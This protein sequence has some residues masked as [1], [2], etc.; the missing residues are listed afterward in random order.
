MPG[1]FRRM[2]ASAGSAYWFGRIV[3]VYAALAL[4]HWRRRRPFAGLSRASYALL[5]ALA[6]GPRVFSRDFWRALRSDHVPGTLHFIEKE[7][8][9]AA[10]ELA[11][12]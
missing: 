7:L 11:A 9:A 2:I 5:A 10:R 1:A 12:E 6:A 8:Q 3:H 4:W